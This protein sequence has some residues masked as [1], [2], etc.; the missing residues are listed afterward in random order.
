MRCIT[1]AEVKTL[2][3]LSVSTY[4]TAIA[5]AI[6]KIDAIVRRLTRNRFNMTAVVDTTSGTTGVVVHEIR[7]ASGFPLSSGKSWGWAATPSDR[8]TGLYGSTSYSRCETEYNPISYFLEVG[9]QVSG[10]G[11]ASGATIVDVYPDGGTIDGVE[12]CAPAIELSADCTATGE[13]T[14][15]TAIPA[16][17][18]YIVAAGV[19]WLVSSDP[20]TPK[21]DTWVSRSMGPLSVS[22]GASDTK[23]DGGSGMPLWFVKALPTYMGGF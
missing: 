19:W 8:H 23:I 2:L 1:T 4:D 20:K 14:I 7:S 11:I 10:I 22:R 16:D 15:Q 21:D 5:A 6:V 3:G 17:L 13:V 12:Y 9:M 18:Q